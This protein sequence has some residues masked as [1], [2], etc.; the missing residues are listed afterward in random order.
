MRGRADLPAARVTLFDTGPETV[1]EVYG[2]A[3]PGRTRRAYRRYRHG[4]GAYK[5]DLAV[6]SPLVYWY[7]SVIF[8]VAGHV[9]SV[10]A[11]HVEA[12]RRFVTHAAALRSTETAVSRV[13][14]PWISE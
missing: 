6:V 4:P 1:A 12:R 7:G 5:V 9:L 8:I 11:A 13:S 2:D 3:L 10:V 14:S